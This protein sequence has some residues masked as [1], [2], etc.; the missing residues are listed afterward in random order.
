VRTHTHTQIKIKFTQQILV[1]TPE[2]TFIKTYPVI[3]EMKHAYEHINMMAL[4]T[5]FTCQEHRR[6]K[7]TDRF[8]LNLQTHGYVSA[9]TFL[10]LWKRQQ[11]V[12]V[13]E[14]DLQN[15]EEDEEPRPEFETSVKTFRMN[16][17]TME[18]E[19]Y[20]PTWSKAWRFLATSSAVLFMVGLH[21]SN[22]FKAQKFNKKISIMNIL[23]WA[24]NPEFY[25]THARS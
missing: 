10:E 20:L 12:I 14:W 3:W 8:T 15:V 19:A 1:Q 13:W 7:Y 9:T 23:P 11:A 25:T 6:H 2:E 18:K 4:C 16:P 21:I 5:Y 22:R 24:C 17:V